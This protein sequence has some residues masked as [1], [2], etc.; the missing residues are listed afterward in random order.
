MTHTAVCMMWTLARG[1]CR[2]KNKPDSDKQTVTMA[3][4]KFCT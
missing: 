3:T 2:V 1:K 4:D